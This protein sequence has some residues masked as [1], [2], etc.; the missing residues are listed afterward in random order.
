M[1]RRWLL[2]ALLLLTGCTSERVVGW[3]VTRTLDGYF[4]FNSAQKVELRASVDE[5]IALIRHQELA[6]WISLLR[7]V[8]QDVHEGMSEQSL[9]RLQ[10]RYDERVE[11]A[12]HLLTPRAA[13]LLVKL[14]DAQ[15]AHFARKVRAD[16]DEQYEDLKL[17]PE[18]RRAKLE[19]KA[20]DV[21]ED[22]V[23]SLDDAQKAQ[24]RALI[25]A[26][27]DEREAQFRSA[28]DRLEHFRAFMHT[29]PTEAALEAE[30]YA[31]WEHR[32]DALGAGHDTETRRTVQ[33]A[34]LLSVYQLLTPAQRAHAEEEL[35]DRI[36]ALK[37][38][39]LPK[40]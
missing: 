37:R 23:E 40:T 31:M 30:L 28:N 15:L 13:P 38:W 6:P 26:L 33:R 14:D 20:L 17:P 35:S 12:V 32:Y 16:L 8:R 18:Q 9:A 2:A 3:Y 10:R 29:R 22:L 36:R 39:V 1:L 19:D 27:P 25:R 5:T 34:W 11:A 24:V 7:E 4:D 21:V